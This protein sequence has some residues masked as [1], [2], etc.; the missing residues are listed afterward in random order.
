M[1]IMVPGNRLYETQ[2]GNPC[3]INR[4][5]NQGLWLNLHWF[6]TSMC[7]IFGHTWGCLIFCWVLLEEKVERITLTTTARPFLPHLGINVHG[8][9]CNTLPILAK[10]KQSPQLTIRHIETWKPEGLG[11]DEGAWLFG[12]SGSGSCVRVLMKFSKVS[13]FL[14]YS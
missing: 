13:F 10:K 1:T 8:H 11:V 2:D 12:G 14:F 3:Y 4:Y 5:G 9:M 7:A 6:R